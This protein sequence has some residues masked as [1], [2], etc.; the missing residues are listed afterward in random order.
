MGTFPRIGGSAGPSTP[1]SASP[2]AATSATRDGTAGHVVASLPPIP[3]NHNL[4][5]FLIQREIGFRPS[6]TVGTVERAFA[7][8]KY[9]AFAAR[10]QLMK[11]DI[12]KLRNAYREEPIRLLKTIDGTALTR[13]FKPKSYVL[14][15]NYYTAI[16]KNTH[17]VF[18][19]IMNILHIDYKKI[20]Y[21]SEL[22]SLEIGVRVLRQI[23]NGLKK[24][25]YKT[26]TFCDLFD[27]NEKVTWTVM[28]E[29]ALSLFRTESPQIRTGQ[30]GHSSA[31][32]QKAF[33]D[34][35]ISSLTVLCETRSFRK[36]TQE[37]GFGIS[38]TWPDVNKKKN[39]RSNIETFIISDAERYSRSYKAPIA[40]FV[41]VDLYFERFLFCY[42]Y[43]H[44]NEHVRASELGQA[45]TSLL[46]AIDWR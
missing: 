38:R 16:E 41:G 17:N 27:M 45:L 46:S 35:A 34:I 1:A 43:A 15:G 19:G 33:R 10:A 40:S 29:T 32:R 28:G 25:P 21:F 26:F 5:H 18:Q 11:F 2:S 37:I 4:S 14:D 6:P 39:Q 31:A 8:V 24:D 30:H 36:A 3:R 20:K 7:A 9:D 44:R 12:C 13:Y 23:S 42:R 22:S